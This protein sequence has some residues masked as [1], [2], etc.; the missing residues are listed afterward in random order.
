MPEPPLRDAARLLSQYNALARYPIGDMDA[1]PVDLL[2]EAQARAALEAARALTS[3]V[4]AHVL[5]G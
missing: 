1:A 5:R 3:W 2:V 4:E